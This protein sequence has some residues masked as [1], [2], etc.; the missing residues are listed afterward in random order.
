MSEAEH[1]D[2]NLPGT[3]RGSPKPGVERG[4]GFL[5][6]SPEEL[7][8]LAPYAPAWRVVPRRG[9]PRL[10]RTFVCNNFSDAMWFVLKVGELAEA[11]SQ[12]PT[13]L[14]DAN[15]V[16]IV[17]RSANSASL[18]RDDFLAASR[19]DAIREDRSRR[20]DA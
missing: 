19:I 3:S 17:L 20:S 2:R 14:I 4:R 7:G 5:G 13:I 15:R 11:E 18:H 9:V 10:E 16:T 6:L 1:P 8:R 12:R